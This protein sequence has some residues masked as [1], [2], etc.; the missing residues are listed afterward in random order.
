MRTRDESCPRPRA[1]EH[2]V[3]GA[4]NEGQARQFHD[5]L[6]RGTSGEGEVV[7]IE[8][9]DRWEAGDACEHLAGPRAAR[10]ALGHEQF[11]NE[12][13]ERRVF[14]G[15]FLRQRGIL[16]GHATEPKLIAELDHALMLD[17]HL[18]SAVISSSYTRSEC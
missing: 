14:L 9:L 17:A 18:S 15:G 3:L 10:L 1:Q 5:L 16:R 11:L 7:L 4:L 13:S 6:A 8:R 2:H 12:V